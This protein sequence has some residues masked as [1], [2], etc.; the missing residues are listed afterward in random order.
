MDKYAYLL[1]PIY[2]F[3]KFYIYLFILAKKSFS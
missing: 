3:I 1:N 2:F